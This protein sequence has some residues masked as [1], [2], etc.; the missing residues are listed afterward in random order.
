MG[1]KVRKVNAILATARE[2]ERETGI[3]ESGF[4]ILHRS[5]VSILHGVSSRFLLQILIEE[6]CQGER[7]PFPTET[8][9]EHELKK[10]YRNVNSN[11][12]ISGF[13]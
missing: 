3:L 13:P 11:R 6:S 5:S 10:T 9:K 4:I 12:Q 2:R 7:G 8:G 1:G